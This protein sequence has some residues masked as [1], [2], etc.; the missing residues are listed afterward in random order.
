MLNYANTP[1]SVEEIWDIAGKQGLLEKLAPSGKTP[2]RTLLV[3]I[4]MDIKNNNYSCFVQTSKRPAKFFIKGKDAELEE[5]ENRHEEE[6]K[7][8]H[9]SKERELHILLSSFARTD[10]HFKCMLRCLSFCWAVLCR[11]RSPDMAALLSGWPPAI[12]SRYFQRV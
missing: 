9:K 11:E 3:R 6:K 7:E 2:I 12:H 5:F 1:L 10:K 8:L 4:Y